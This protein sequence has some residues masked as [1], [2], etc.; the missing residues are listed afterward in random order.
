MK[1][2]SSTS[3]VSNTNKKNKILP[4]VKDNSH[5]DCPICFTLLECPILLPSC[6][7]TFCKSCL[8][9]WKAEKKSDDCDVLN[10]GNNRHCLFCVWGYRN[11]FNVRF[12]LK[13]QILFVF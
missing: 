10:K 13:I 1:R 3:D 12:H 8:L 9:E 11:K 6:G 7:H 2:N 5:L 4:S